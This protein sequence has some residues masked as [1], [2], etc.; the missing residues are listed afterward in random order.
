MILHLFQI[1]QKN[2]QKYELRKYDEGEVQQEHLPNKDLTL[3]SI[4]KIKSLLKLKKM[5]SIILQLKLSQQSRLIMLMS[6]KF[7]FKSKL[8]LKK[9][10]HP[11]NLSLINEMKLT[12]HS[13]NFHQ[14]RYIIL[15]LH[16]I[17]KLMKIDFHLIL[18]CLLDKNRDLMSHPQILQSKSVLK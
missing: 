10:L 8:R 17:I 6:L 15:I 7:T 1:L 18:L 13:F 12:H 9:H 14:I 11:N 3:R 2:K 4:S 5:Q 16:P